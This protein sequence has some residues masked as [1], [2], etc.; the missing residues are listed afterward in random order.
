VLFWLNIL[1]VRG[2]SVEAIVREHWRTYGRNYYSRHDYEGVAI[3]RAND[4]VALVQ[5]AMPTLKGRRFGVYEVDYADDF[6]YTDSIDGSVSNKQ[7]M[8]IGFTDGSRIVLRLSGTGTQG[9]TLRVYF[10][11]FMA[12]SAQHD[13]DVQEA[14]G[15]LM[16]IVEELAQIRKHTGMDQPTVIT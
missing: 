8:R 13:R 6:S 5:G 10:E 16:A 14:L 9:A 15:G 12:D 7:G 4:L 11:S 2:E 1:A 3:D